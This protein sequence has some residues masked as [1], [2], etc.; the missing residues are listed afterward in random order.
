MKKTFITLLTAA[1]VAIPSVAVAQEPATTNPGNEDLVVE[2]EV[3][4]PMPDEKYRV[5]TNTFWHNWFLQADLGASMAF[6][7]HD[8]QV[9][10]RKRITPAAL[11]AVGKWFTP[12]IGVRAA[13]QGYQV[14]GLTQHFP[15]PG[16]P[17][18]AHMGRPYRIWNEGLYYQKFNYFNVHLDMML[19]LCQMIGGYKADR[20]YSAIPFFGIGIAQ[21]T[22]RPRSTELAF[23]VGLI[24]S[25]RL[26]KRWD[27]NVEFN[28]MITDERFSGEDGNRHFDA[29]LNLMVGATFR[30]GKVGWDRPT[31]R[32]VTVYDNAAINRL[33]AENAAL[34][35]ENARLA[36]EANH[37]P[38]R[39][40]E[41]IAA[42][43]V[44]FFKI[45]TWEITDK[46]RAN[47]SFLADAIKK[48]SVKYT[49]TGYADK[50]TGTP[51]WNSQL[52]KRR[53]EAAYQCL[54]NEFG[55]PAD[56][57]IIDYKGGV[58]DMFYND[59]RCSRCVIVLPKE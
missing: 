45:D 3:I 1:A 42:G 26:S 56:K 9:T 52:S 59:P 44:I 21:V 54:V 10:I 29:L 11:F 2:S 35:A 38:D 43:N 55:I 20:F 14:K 58:D 34:A 50:G 48:S 19:N 57:L 30:L 17:K 49:V 23:N 51:E 39:I 15:A 28:S 8:R 53:A 27:L 13:I 47:L 25:F 4:T 31:D 24:N 5:V 40:E 16:E 18:G 33:R 22:E 12:G 36:A 41:L 7:D 32:T 37:K 6:T 46:S